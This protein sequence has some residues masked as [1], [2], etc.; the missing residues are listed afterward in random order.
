M[1]EENVAGLSFCG[2]S[3]SCDRQT[4]R[5]TNR[6]TDPPHKDATFVAELRNSPVQLQH[7]ASLIRMLPWHTRHH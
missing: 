1:A 2:C 6:W 3:I 7:S 5:Q 4:D